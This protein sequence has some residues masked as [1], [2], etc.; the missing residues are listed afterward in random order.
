MIR[1]V[2][3]AIDPAI[4]SVKD[5]APLID[6]KVH[7][8]GSVPP[9][10]MNELKHPDENFFIAG[11][12]SYGRAP[13]LLLTTGY[14]QVRSIAAYLTGDYEAANNVELHLPET[15]VCSTDFILDTDNHQACC[16]RPAPDDKESCCADY[17]E[18]KAEGRS[19]C[20]CGTEKKL[21]LP[22]AP[23]ANSFRMTV[24]RLLVIVRS[25]IDQ[26]TLVSWL[27]VS[28]LIGWG[29]FY[30]AFTL[31]NDPLKQGV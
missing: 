1:E 11:L 12:K 31:F 26:I 7:S 13:N 18:A 6:P 27:S 29:T 24:L 22:K 8:C 16:G 25:E 4:V 30:Y 21:H 20:G 9:H 10:R 3:T 2:R 23:A 15:G 14:E 17:A 28:Q 19:D 5:L